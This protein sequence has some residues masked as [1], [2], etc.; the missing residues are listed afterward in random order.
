MSK[1]TSIS[2]SEYEHNTLT[3]IA[4]ANNLYKNN[5]TELSVSMALK[6]VLREYI[7]S[8]EEIKKSS[9]NENSMRI[10]EQIHATLPHIMFQ[11]TLACQA[12]AVPLD[13]DKKVGLR[14]TS[15]DITVETCG[16]FQ[17]V[18]YEE[19]TTSLDSRNIKS[20][21]IDKDKNQW[22]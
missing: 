16:Q 17:E 2:L 13:R 3:D 5:S 19:I 11:A 18:S 10:L 7:K 22:K 21:P 14:N 20:L 12:S 1:V 15:M 4:K 9:F 8:Q 6:Y